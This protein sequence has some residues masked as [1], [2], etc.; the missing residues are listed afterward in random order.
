MANMDLSS[1][2]IGQASINVHDI[3]PA[4][5]FYRDA[6][7]LRFL[8]QAPKMRSSIAAGCA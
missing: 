3:E 6:L 1:A 4:I 5:A 8:F 7:G 2:S